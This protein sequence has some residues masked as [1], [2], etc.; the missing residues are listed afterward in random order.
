MDIDSVFSDFPI[1]LMDLKQ[2]AK[3]S[4]GKTETFAVIL[5][6]LKVFLQADSGNLSVGL[7]GGITF[8][9]F[10]SLEQ[11]GNVKININ[12]QLVEGSV[13]YDVIAIMLEDSS[14][15]YAPFY[16]LTIQKRNK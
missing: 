3:S 13:E 6:G 5:S 10:L 9:A 15:D 12:N 8:T 16:K 4:S 11:L 1:K 7:L 2:S 14:P